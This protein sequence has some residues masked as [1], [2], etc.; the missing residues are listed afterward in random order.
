[1]SE[2][3]ARSAQHYRV[4]CLRC[5][6]TFLAR[7]A[8][9]G[10]DVECPHCSSVLSVPAP[11][12]DGRPVRAGA[13]SVVPKKRFNFACA[14]CECLLETNTGMSGQTGRCP[15]CAAQFIIPYVNPHSGVADRARLVE[16]EVD[17]PTPLHAYAASGHQAPRIVRLDT[18]E[19]VIACARCGAQSEI[20]ADLRAGCGVPFTIEATPSIGSIESDSR[21]VASLVLGIVG[22]PLTFLFV[23]AAL[24]VIFGFSS[25]RRAGGVGVPKMAV[26]GIILGVI[27]LALALI[28]VL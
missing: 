19:N 15:T 6:R 23:P 18:G 11:S 21:A 4:V 14:R 7:S 3:D 10:R 24:A 17:D 1:M 9:T 2:S 8:W 20:D 13:P 16:S 5:N 22:L 26:A 25:L 28:L 12:E 27:S